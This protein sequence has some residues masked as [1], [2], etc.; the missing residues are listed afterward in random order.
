MNSRLVPGRVVQVNIRDPDDGFFVAYMVKTDRLSCSLPSNTMGVPRDTEA[1]CVRE[2]CLPMSLE[3][4]VMFCAQHYVTLPKLRFAP[5]ERV[6]FRVEDGEGGLDQWLCGTV[7]ETWPNI[8]GPCEFAGVQFCDTVPYSLEADSTTGRSERTYY[9]HRDD[10]TLVRRED[11]MPQKRRKGIAQRM[12]KRALAGSTV[13]FDHA[14]CRSRE[15]Q[16]ESESSG[17]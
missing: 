8:P 9:C 10:H 12:E 11:H 16:G 14:T 15:V 6:S 7:K 1:F 17:E 2:T 3:K 13:I 5:G 4:M